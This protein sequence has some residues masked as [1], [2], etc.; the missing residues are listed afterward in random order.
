MIDAVSI[1]QLKA[2]AR[3]GGVFLALLWVASFAAMLFSPASSWG[4]LLA[5]AT[6]FFVG[7]LL[8]RFRNYALKGVISFRRSFAF[9]VLTFFYASL[10]F[11]LAQYV[12]FR[13]LDNGVF[14]SHLVTNVN[15]LEDVYKQQG[16][17]VTELNNGLNLMGQMSPIQMSLMFMVQNIMIGVVLSVPVA[18]IC[19]KKH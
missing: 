10:I 16:V 1:V 11:A 8:Q 12:Y 14:M 13:F 5:L 7:W 6:P 4:S 3:Q 9:S 19:K 2:F 18:L 17:S 15:I